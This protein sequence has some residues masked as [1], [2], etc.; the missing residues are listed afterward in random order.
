MKNIRLISL[1]LALV[2]CLAAF[3][4]CGDATTTDETTKAPNSNN[5]EETTE[6][7]DLHPEIKKNEYNTEFYLSIMTHVNQTN[8]YWVEESSNDVLTDAVFQRQ[9][10]L[11]EYLGVDM[12][13]IEEFDSESYIT[14]L[15]TAVKNR[16]DSVHLTLSHTFMGIEGFITG[17]YLTDF[18]DID[19]IDINSDHWNEEFMEEVSIN[20]H[21]FLGYS[22]F[23]IA[24]TQVVAF[25]K[26]MYDKYDDAIGE[27]F[28]TMVTDY[29][30]TLDKMISIANL[31]YIDATSD[32]KT[33]DDTFGLVADFEV[34]YASLLQACNISV[35]DMNDKG[36]YI[37]SVYTE[38]NNI[39]TAT[40]VDKLYNLVR[41]N[42]AYLSDD[43]TYQ[44]PGK[45]FAADRALMHFARTTSL[46]GFLNDGINFGVLP[47]PMYDEAQKNVGYRSLQWGGYLCI[48]SYLAN[49]DMAY[50]TVE[51]LAYIS[52]KVNVAYY[53]K[54]LG[55]QVADAPQD[56]KMLDIVWN[57]V[58]SDFGLTYSQVIDEDFHYLML[59][60]L[61]GM[62]GSKDIASYVSGRVTN[63][64]KKLSK[65]T[66][67]VK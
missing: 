10:Y 43:P 12:F 23:N 32:G 24:R 35:V 13:A 49:E 60:N 15:Q 62:G 44:E 63:A 8:L 1:L 39:K 28:Y 27:E 46:P 59:Y 42:G 11:K 50:E 52:D 45:I 22:D 58:C 38:E 18:N 9:E 51:L 14:R 25:N 40:L 55:K 64:N 33:I 20:G 48:P 54:L 65:F 19:V 66:S 41:T 56:R 30:W 2:L 6:N 37:I 67:K 21:M 5:S 57:S 53:E 17:N 36:Q 7:S 34:P 3:V 61:T 4:G 29:R 16:D 31:V 47:Y 26:D